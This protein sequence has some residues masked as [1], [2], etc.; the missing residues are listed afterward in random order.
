MKPA[1]IVTFQIINWR[2]NDMICLFGL[3][4]VRGGK[5][6]WFEGPSGFRKFFCKTERAF[7]VPYLG[8]D[9]IFKLQ[10]QPSRG[11]LRRKCSENMQQIY[12]RT[13]MPKCDP[14]NLLHIFRTH[15]LKVACVVN[16]KLFF[17]ELILLWFDNTN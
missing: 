5:M 10:K 12:R 6:S 17:Y 13:P 14:V 9:I 2:F 7:C 8:N 1:N 16:I 15:F 11:A 3:N 4:A